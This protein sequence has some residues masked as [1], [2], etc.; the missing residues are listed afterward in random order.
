MENVGDVKAK[1]NLQ[2]LF[3]VGEI[4]SRCPKDQHRFEIKDKE[5]TYKEPQNEAFKDKDKAKS[6]NS[7]TSANQPQTQAPKKDKRGCWGGYTASGV[8]ATEIVKKNKTPK[9]LSHIRCYTHYQ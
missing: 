6:H 8:N 5:D 9:D 7:S 1:V 2:P 3:Y 4:D